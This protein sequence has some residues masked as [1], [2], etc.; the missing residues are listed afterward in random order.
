MKQ[1]LSFKDAVE[2]YL[3]DPELFQQLPQYPKIPTE[4]R[5]Y[6]P[7]DKTLLLVTDND[8]ITI[9]GSNVFQR[10][11]PILKLLNGH[12]NID[13]LIK[14]NPQINKMAILGII[15]FL[16]SKKILE[17]GN[18]NAKNF[19]SSTDKSLSSYLGYL[20]S[21]NG[22]KQSRE[23]LY[24][25]IYKKKIRVINDNDSF[26]Q[27]TNLAKQINNNTIDDDTSDDLYIILNYNDKNQ[28]LVK[29]I[30]SA[31]YKKKPLIFV[32]STYNTLLIGP[33]ILPGYG[34]TPGCFSDFL[35][36]TKTINIPFD[37]DPL[38]ISSS[39]IES[40]IVSFFSL[41][42]EHV[43]ISSF[44]ELK[45][46]TAQLEITKIKIP[47]TH[48]WTTDLNW[49]KNEL[50]YIDEIKDIFDLHIS[51]QRLPPL[52][53][54]NI[55]YEMHYY[56]SNRR[57]AELFI[58]LFPNTMGKNEDSILN[59]WMNIK[60]LPICTT[61]YSINP[62]TNRNLCPSGGNIKSALLF[63]SVYDNELQ[64]EFYF[65][66]NPYDNSFIKIN[67]IQNNK[68]NYDYSTQK[69]N[70]KFI[71]LSNI[72]NLKEKYFDLSL[73]IS[74]LDAGVLAELVKLSIALHNLN[75]TTNFFNN[76]ES[77]KDNLLLKNNSMIYIGQVIEIFQVNNKNNYEKEN[78]T[79]LSIKSL[80]SSLK[81]SILDDVN[82]IPQA[83]ALRSP[84]EL[85]EMLS[86]REAVR[87]LSS[88]IDFPFVLDV[89]KATLTNAYYGN[90][91]DIR[92]VIM[93]KENNN[94]RSIHAM[95][96]NG[97]LCSKGY[98]TE[99]VAKTVLMQDNLSKAGCIVFII[100]NLEK[101]I[102]IY[103]ALGYRIAMMEAGQKIADLW[104]SCTHYDLVGCPCGA[105]SEDVLLPYGIDGY[106]NTIGG[107]FA[108]GK[109]LI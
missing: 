24:S 64:K 106:T 59:D 94:Q 23:D 77:Y 14:D 89:V 69:Y 10:V 31:I 55:G 84:R 44:I 70:C 35:K 53:R 81:T 21:N 78:N 102:R 38:D 103:G 36:N 6:E 45:K 79:P 62:N 66:Y 87:D 61:I 42:M 19:I 95:S 2:P 108:F 37:N 46:P 63:I 86:Q 75:Y 11:I 85:Y 16:Y 92:Y 107:T 48:H 43:P 97:T 71:I 101:Y 39:I 1:T 60:I 56:P 5:F 100:I 93:H 104:L 50:I 65:Q 27:F 26:L 76:E 7:D 58:P 51:T 4:L 28:Q 32:T 105:F 80:K 8:Y 47:Y 91:D 49:S 25:E 17:N 83:L 9:N 33:M 34:V 54:S 88:N 3:L 73:R 40:I 13:L 41:N 12:K 18:N 90:A 57:L 72:K 20:T 52:Y 29:T 22:H 15:A 30:S 109:T 68:N 82:F 99:K 74:L 98:I 96:K 67:E